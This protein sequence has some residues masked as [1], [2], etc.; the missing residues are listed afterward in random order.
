MNWELVR[1]LATMKHVEK[2]SSKT[3][4]ALEVEQHLS[5]EIGLFVPFI[6]AE[7]L[8]FYVR[9][10][11]KLLFHVVLKLRFCQLLSNVHSHQH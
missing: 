7:K 6:K 3:A 9:T 10:K 5:E 4:N 1:T 2:D 8:I 11:Q